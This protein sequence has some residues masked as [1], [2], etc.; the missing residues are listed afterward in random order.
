MI[1]KPDRNAGLI[2][3]LTHF[4]LTVAFAQNHFGSGQNLGGAHYLAV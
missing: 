4:K 2:G 1:G 3:D